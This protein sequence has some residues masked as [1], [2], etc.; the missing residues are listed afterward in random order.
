M[1]FT[2]YLLVALIV[3][4]GF[5]TGTAHAAGSLVL[6]SAVSESY[7]TG[8]QYQ[9][10]KKIAAELNVGLILSYVPFPRRLHQLKQGEIDLM[11]G[12]SY[13]KGRADYIYYLK[14][15]YFNNPI[16]LFVRSDAQFNIN[17]A[18]DIGALNIGVVKSS[19]YFPELDNSPNKVPIST[20]EQLVK[21]VSYGRLDGFVHNKKGAE[22]KVQ[23]MEMQSQVKAH[24]FI[25]PV[26]NRIFIGISKKSWLYRNKKMLAKIKKI[27]RGYEKLRS[28]YY[29][30][31]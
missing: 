17:S 25:L 7:K 12:V 24:D 18:E 2:S 16:G 28:H 26:D 21:M 8:L 23:Q 10:L 11:V 5:N 9:F 22:K 27:Q 20:V 29:L 6:K 3:T 13:R 31:N 14:P 19:K 15:H 30:E 4:Y 1:R